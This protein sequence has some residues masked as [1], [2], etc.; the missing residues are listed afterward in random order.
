MT[1]PGDPYRV[2]GLVPGASAEEVKHA[3]RRLAKRFH[4]D[5]AG[6][7]ATARFLL[8]Q[9]AYEALAHPAPGASATRRRSSARPAP[10][11]RPGP[12]PG[13]RRGSP[14]SGGG[15]S[16]PGTGAGP[17]PGRGA[18]G[19]SGVRKARPGSTSYDEAE[20]DAPEPGWRGATWYGESSGTYWTINPR[21]Y[22]D[23]RKH[24]PE[25][26]AR[27]RHLSESPAGANGVP[28]GATKVG[29]DGDTDRAGAGAADAAQ[30]PAG[31]ADA[32]RS[33]TAAR[34]ENPGPSTPGS[35]ATVRP[36]GSL[37]G[38]LGRVAAGILGCRVGPSR[39]PGGG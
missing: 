4:P 32:D 29:W 2:L 18:R 17:G 7:A 31:A 35:D 9:A 5:S 6:D 8:V 15:P 23:P 13:T 38:R 14:R 12:A 10:G 34:S 30:T 25:Y 19:Q 33:S 20:G 24:G 1:N 37:V 21:E 27:G 26:Q 22:S 11:A 39:R 36:P 16:A 28:R 3:Y